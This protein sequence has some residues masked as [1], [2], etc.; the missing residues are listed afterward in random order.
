MAIF[1]ACGK[2]EQ[3]PVVGPQ[4]S[5]PLSWSDRIKSDP[6]L[7]EAQ[8]AQLLALIPL[9]EISDRQEAL[10]RKELV[11]PPPVGWKPE[12]VR[13]KLKL[14]IIP[15]KTIIRRGDK[16]R[17][18]MEI[19]NVGQETILMSE[20]GYSFVKSG[21]LNYSGPYKV[22]VTPPGG[23]EEYLPSPRSAD[24]FDGGNVK[25]ERYDY[26]ENMSESQRAAEIER[27]KWRSSAEIGL[28]MS[29]RPGEILVTR[30]DDPTR[31]RF[32]VLKTRLKLDEPGAYRLRVVYD[33]PPLP[34]PSEAEIQEYI[35]RGISRKEQMALIA[36]SVRESLGRIEPNP[37]V[38]EVV[39]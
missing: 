17:Y 38:F 22:F 4:A 26:L 9:G 23:Q 27:I 20:S 3:A 30:P 18:R 19:Q 10:D 11:L 2:K 15:E 39:P 36:F 34:V 5:G 13:R 33:N 29:L 7:N 37:V 12:P 25:L 14:T 1:C 31:D 32:C 28:R 8:K 16:F 24:D 35:R 21:A 6:K